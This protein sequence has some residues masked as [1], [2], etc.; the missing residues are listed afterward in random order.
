[1]NKESYVPLKATAI[2]FQ[3]GRSVS[4]RLPIRPQQEESKKRSGHKNQNIG[5][6]QVKQCGGKEKKTFP[7]F[8]FPLPFSLPIELK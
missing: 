7:A 8:S 4:C 3:D 2:P 6:L 1:M 5:G